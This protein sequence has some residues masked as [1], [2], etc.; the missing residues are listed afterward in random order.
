M[1]EQPH[2]KEHQNCST[3]YNRKL[4]QALLKDPKIN[5]LMAIH[6]LLIID[7]IE[8]TNDARIRISGYKNSKGERPFIDIPFD[9]SNNNVEVTISKIK[10]R[11]IT[12][13]DRP[14][15]V[16]ELSLDTVH[17]LSSFEDSSQQKAFYTIAELYNGSHELAYGIE[18]PEAL[19]LRSYSYGRTP[20]ERESEE[21]EYWLKKIKNTDELITEKNIV[22]FWWEKKALHL[23]YECGD[24]ESNG[25][26]QQ[27]VLKQS[28]LKMVTDYELD[29]QVRIL[30]DEKDEEIMSELTEN[31]WSEEIGIKAQTFITD[32][33][34][35]LIQ[36]YEEAQSFIKK[37][38]T[39]L[40]NHKTIGLFIEFLY[41][42]SN[43][44]EESEEDDEEEPW[45]RS[46]K[47]S[48]EDTPLWSWN[49]RIYELGGDEENDYE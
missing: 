38:Q 10:N 32:K 44:D 35:I 20:E 14:I 18:Y 15:D 12:F 43:D 34:G 1:K 29:N 16:K 7:I 47:T 42:S 21:L 9:P 40:Y 2:R 27:M 37:L 31:K 17:D 24:D 45:L 6:H 13:F 46:L 19:K 49:I 23:I 41:I 30:D 4:Q 22:S 33:N 26:L 8:R 11:I 25:Y 48:D 28:L 3:V 5:G 36:D 39:I